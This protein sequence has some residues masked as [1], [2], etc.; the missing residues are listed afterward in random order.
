MEATRSLLLWLGM[1]EGHFCAAIVLPSWRL[2]ACLCLATIACYCVLTSWLACAWLPPCLLVLLGFT[3]PS[4]L[5]WVGA[6]SLLLLGLVPGYLGA[7]WCR[8]AVFESCLLAC[9]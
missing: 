7:S 8:L 6:R 2:L 5:C 9:F 1:L 4:G 3:M